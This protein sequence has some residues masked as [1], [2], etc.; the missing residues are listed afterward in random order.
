MPDEKILSITQTRENIK[1]I[2]EY[3]SIN[4]SEQTYSTALLDDVNWNDRFNAFHQ[5]ALD[6]GACAYWLRLKIKNLSEQNLDDWFLHF[7][8]ASFIEAYVLDSSNELISQQLTGRMRPSSEKPFIY[9]NRFERIRLNI[10]KDQL[11]T[12]YLRF[13]NQNGY[14]ARVDLSLGPNDYYKSEE[15]QTQRILDGL[16]IG[17]LVSIILF[18]LIFFF[19]TRDVTFFYQFLFVS[20]ILIF[21]FDIMDIICE[22]PLLRNLPLLLVPINFSSIVLLNIAYLNFIHYFIQLDKLYTGWNSLFKK[23]VWMNLAGGVCIVLFYIITKNERISDTLIALVCTLQYLVLLALLVRLI[24]YRNKKAFFILVA[25]FL[26]ITGVIVDGSFVAMGLGVPKSFTKLIILGNVSFFFFG[27]AYRMKLLKEEEHE[28]IRLKENQELKNKL[29]AN[30]THEF[31][32]PLTVIQGMAQQIESNVVQ[33]DQSKLQQAVELIKSNGNRLLTLVNSILDLAKIESGKMELNPSRTDIISFLRYL[34]H[35]FESFA[36]LKKIQLNF[37]TELS[38]LIINIDKEKMQQVVSNLISNA[39][40]FTPKDGKIYFTVK[41]LE[42][43]KDTMLVI[44]VKDTGEGIPKAEIGNLFNRFFQAESSKHKA[45]G[46]GLGLALVNELVQLMN[47]SIEVE[48]EVG[49]GTTFRIQLPVQTVEAEILEE[50]YKEYKVSAMDSSS[51]ELNVGRL[52]P[53]AGTGKPLL[54]IVDDNKDILYYLQALLENS[55]VIEIAFNGNEGMELALE[56]IPDVIISDVLMPDK[57]GYE[58]CAELK[59]DMRTSHIPVILLTAK[60]ESTSRIEGLR[61]GAD[62]YLAKPFDELE[63]K[64]LLENLLN[65]RK[66]LQSH[67]S[68]MHSDLDV[69]GLDEPIENAFLV[70]LNSIIAENLDDEDFGILQLCRSMQMSRTQLHRKITALTGKSTSIYLR[71]LRLQKAKE[72]LRHQELNVSEVAFAVGFSDPNYFTRTFTEEFGISPSKYKST[73]S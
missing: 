66:S 69:A 24:Q 28:A 60:T 23:L 44:E 6:C 27:L 58:L 54:L 32:T 45:Q 70:K 9:G 42:H 29:Y 35:S 53:A 37:L 73:A 46:S 36:E 34:V 50:D 1:G 16:F 26:L 8:K 12:V 21:L 3:L 49:K 20:G 14:H 62:A 41:K 22:I 25:T 47:G 13:K 63:L 7:G 11:L 57:D 5:D 71:S 43:N 33:K 64:V 17:Y 19:T 38:T 48:S 65:N 56:L 2:N 18:N 67:Y 59:K 15:Y 30:I 55:Y 39:L 51:K 68:S 52:T 10:A 40:K 61:K 72:L 31:R 4:K